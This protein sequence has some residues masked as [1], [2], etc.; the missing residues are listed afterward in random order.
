MVA[1]ASKNSVNGE[2]PVVKPGTLTSTAEVESAD[3]LGNHVAEALDRLA[4]VFA[5]KS[6]DCT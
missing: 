3:L 6:P 5:L 2:S 1:A 4:A